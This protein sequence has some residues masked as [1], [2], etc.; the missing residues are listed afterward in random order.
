M[1]NEFFRELL[2]HIAKQSST[3]RSSNSVVYMQEMGIA[4]PEIDALSGREQSDL[5]DKKTNELL[6]VFLAMQQSP[7]PDPDVTVIHFDKDAM[8]GDPEDTFF[9]NAET[10]RNIAGKLTARE[11][12][13]L[14]VFIN[15][16]YSAI[17]KNNALVS[18]VHV[19]TL[20]AYLEEWLQP[21]LRE[22]KYDGLML[23]GLYNVYDVDGTAITNYMEELAAKEQTAVAIPEDILAQLKTP[24]CTVLLPT[25]ADDFLPDPRGLELRPLANGLIRLDS[26]VLLHK[27]FIVSFSHIN[28]VIAFADPAAIYA[29]MGFSG[30]GEA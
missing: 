29:K 11:M 7:V 20:R 12:S 14:F 10:M 13:E 9:F 26:F 18:L 3:T 25:L 6:N 27:R 1:A 16:T 4:D 21:F 2:E 24:A 5:D 23:L 15:S 22:A 17:R 19:P 8:R 28:K 30:G